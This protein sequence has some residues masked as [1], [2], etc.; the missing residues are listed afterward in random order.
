MEEI[1]NNL[2]ETMEVIEPVEAIEVIEDSVEENG[3]NLVA[4]I[5]TGVAIG[6]AGYFAVKK[7]AKWRKAK[8]ELTDAEVN[9]EEVTVVEDEPEEIEADI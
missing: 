3:T 6:V 7:Y 9:V 4:L 2:I 1:T 8:K 5:A